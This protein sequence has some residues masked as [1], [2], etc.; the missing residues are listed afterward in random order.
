M[1]QIH[2]K[3]LNV[4][5][6]VRTVALVAYLCVFYLLAPLL[7]ICQDENRH[8]ATELVTTRC[9]VVRAV[10]SPGA[11]QVPDTSIDAAKACADSCT[12]TPLL[13]GIDVFSCRRL[14]PE[15][16]S[17]PA[18]PYLVVAPCTVPDVSYGDRGGRST[19]SQHAIGRSTVL[20][21]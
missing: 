16:E 15:A 17:L 11:E 5:M 6:R 10:G 1:P 12:D 4:P 3:N 20:L 2:L 9:C 21:I 18:V 14:A 8:A 13:A 19:F 7:V